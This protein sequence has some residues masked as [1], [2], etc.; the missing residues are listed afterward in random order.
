MHSV[1]EEYISVVRTDFESFIPSS[2]IMPNPSKSQKHKITDQ[3]TPVIPQKIP[4][5][6]DTPLTG[7]NLTFD[8]CVK[9]DYPRSKKSTS[10]EAEDFIGSMWPILEQKLD[11]W[12]EKSLTKKN[13]INCSN[14]S[15]QICIFQ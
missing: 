7:T 11:C 1:F 15:R 10:I 4:D 3:H 12:I 8:D 14:C 5:K 13:R 9:G 6:K 2:T